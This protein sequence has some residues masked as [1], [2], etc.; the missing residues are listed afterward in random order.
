MSGNLLIAERLGGKEEF[1]KSEVMFF[2]L[3]LKHV[4]NNKFRYATI[5]LRLFISFNFIHLF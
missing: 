1:C 4:I 5:K 3:I 2:N